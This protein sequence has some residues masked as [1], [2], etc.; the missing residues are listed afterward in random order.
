[1]RQLTIIL[2]NCGPDDE[3]TRSIKAP[4]ILTP[5]SLARLTRRYDERGADRRFMVAH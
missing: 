3:K 1:M 2:K 4:H 5:T